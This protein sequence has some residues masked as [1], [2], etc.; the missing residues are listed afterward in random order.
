[1]QSVLPGGLNAYR[2]CKGLTR[3]RCG[4]A[5]PLVGLLAILLICRFGGVAGA[6]TWA[7]EKLVTEPYFN[8]QMLIREAGQE[9][10]ELVLLLH[11]LGDEAGTTW[12]SLLPE[13]AGHYHVVA[14]DLPGFGRSAKGNQLYTPEAYATI[15]AWL[16]A[17]LPDKPLTLVGHSLGGAVAMVYASQHSAELKLLVLVDAVGTLHRLAL[18]QYFVRQQLRLEVP[19]FADALQSSLGK[20]AGLLLEKTS[21]IPLDPDLILASAELRERFLAGDPARIAALALVET[22]FSLLLPR[23]RVPTWLLWGTEDQVAPLRIAK[24]LA[25]NLPQAQL[26]LLNGLGHTPMA[27]N[28]AAFN[29][30]LLGRLAR[31][32]QRPEPVASPAEVTAGSCEG[33]NGRVFSGHYATLSIQRCRNVRLENLSARHLEIRNS[34]VTMESSQV[35][36][37]TDTPALVVSHSRLT[38]TGVDLQGAVG[39]LTEQSR[40]DLAGV[41]FIDTP[42]AISTIGNPSALLSSSSVKFIGNRAQGLQMNRSLVAG[43]RL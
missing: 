27:E 23:I 35:H 41:R 21:R 9:H 24:L 36:S 8:G 12:D 25:W 6:A 14:P 7:S 19:F 40:L 30:A 31:N 4:P 1:M 37:L 15:V 32:P 26:V 5:W 43:D 18:S 39:I 33:E 29:A 28:P 34:E 13:L 22:D 3:F 2:Q 17:T 10:P 42:I 16:V 38:L 11:G 20:V